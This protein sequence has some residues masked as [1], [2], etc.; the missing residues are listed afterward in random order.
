MLADAPR[1]GIAK[2][3]LEPVLGVEGCVRLQ[4]AL[5]SRAA[6][7]ATGAGPAWVAHVPGDAGE[8][9]AALVPPGIGTFAQVDGSRGER[10]ATAFGRVA[11]EHDGPI[12][13]IGTDH[14]ALSE[15]HVRAVADDMREGVDVTFGP[16]TGGGW[17]LLAAARPHPAL[18]A[19]DEEAWGGPEALSLTI[20]SVV[21]AGLSMGWLTW[22]RGLEAPDDVDALL[23]DPCAPADIVAALR[24]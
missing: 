3:R 19:I 10:V 12:V 24:G 8:D 15:R 18:F 2:P 22:E 9:V 6:R 13:V 5:I 11:E 14:P 1:P 17:Y 4:R 7:W 20:A 16:G 23:A 21:G